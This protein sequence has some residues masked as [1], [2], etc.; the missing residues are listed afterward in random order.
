MKK[1][2]S[3]ILCVLLLASLSGAALA[4]EAP[5]TF[6]YTGEEVVFSGFAYDGLDQNP[7]Q[8]GMQA[9]QEHIGNMRVDY[10]FIAYTDY[11]EKA[12][13]LLATGDIPDVLPSSTSWTW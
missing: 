8:P 1:T 10:E 13:I 12:Q 9:W 3:L 11:L 5:I 2:L 4:E 6:P 7:E